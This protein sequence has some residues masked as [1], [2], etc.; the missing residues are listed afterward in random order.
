MPI[1]EYKCG[2]C[3]RVT[4]H[5][6]SGFSEKAPSCAHCGSDKLSKLFSVPSS[7]RAGNAHSHADMCGGMEGACGFDQGG[8]PPC[9]MT[10]GSC[11]HSG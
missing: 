11:G 8:T 10:P 6:A 4:E 7:P 9:G 2:E 1:Y 3:G 5:L